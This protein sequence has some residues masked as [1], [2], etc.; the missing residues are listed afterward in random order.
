[1][2]KL[3][4]I[5]TSFLLIS[6]A[7]AFDN[8]KPPEGC[9][10]PSFLDKLTDNNWRNVRWY[11]EPEPNARPNPYAGLMSC[12]YLTNPGSTTCDPTR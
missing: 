11:C 7:F 1:M 4:I 3:V 2:K 5:A 12:N 10:A 9:H 6:S 8:D